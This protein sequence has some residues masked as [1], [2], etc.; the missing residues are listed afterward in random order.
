MSS[1]RI[2]GP[3]FDFTFTVLL[4]VTL[5]FVAASG[6]G[7]AA[8][9]PDVLIA[10][11]EGTNYGTWEITGQ[12][13]G[14]GPAAGTL[15]HQMQVDGYRG[16]KLA[17]SFYGGDSSTGT[18]K[19]ASF[20]LERRYLQFLIGGG[21]QPGKACINLWVDGRNAR[22]ATG[23]NDRPGGSEH[24]DWMQWDV[25]EFAGRTATLEIV[26]QATGGWG[27]INI[28]HIVQ[29]DRRLPGMLTN[30]RHE[31]RVE[32]RYLNFPVKNGVPK[33]RVSVAVQASNGTVI[34]PVNSPIKAE[35]GTAGTERPTFEFEI[36]LAETEPDFWVF[37]DLAPFLG[38]T[39]T[40]QVDKLREDSTALERIEQSATIRGAETLY[41]EPLRPQFHFTSRRGWN[42]DPNGLVFYAGEYH[43]FYQHNPYGWGW[44]NMHW[45]HAISADLVHWRELPIAL[46]PHAFGDWVF[47][48]S[49]VV[50]ARNTGGFK[51]G[52]NDVL[53][54]AYTSTGRGECIAYS[55]DRGRT[56]TEFAGN[57]VVR[58]AGRDPR[59]LWHEPSQRWVMAVYD[60]ADGKR[61]IAF[62]TSAD[63]RAW[64]YQSR[65][66]GFFECPDLFELPVDGDA[67]NRKWV[68]TAA[69]SEYRLGQFDGQRFTPETPMLPGHRGNAFYAAQTYSD[70]PPSDGRRIQIGWG[71]MPTPGMPFNQMMCFPCRLT[72]RTTPE[73]VRLCFEPVEE[74][75]RLHAREHHWKDRA[76][77]PGENPLAA[78]TAEL[79]HVRLTVAPG[80]ASE[81]RLNLRG[82]PIVYRTATAELSFANR[83]AA[84][85]LV[86]GALQLE[87]LVDRTSVELF[88]NG[89]LLYMPVNV[90]V[91]PENRAHSLT[92]TGHARIR[93]LDVYELTSAWTDAA[94]RR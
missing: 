24:L 8:E 12:A 33:R 11:F 18:L 42:N 90:T 21:Q 32:Q 27:H 61:W 64:Q 80:D 74:L 65:I 37:L 53:V 31:L 36:E 79:L 2:G 28:D 82:V 54:A 78:V 92:A 87:V 25:A 46:Y 6:S 3:A 66:E 17:N 75:A 50:D 76:L 52:T 13:F 26:D 56:W 55:N 29:T 58:H 38:K 60:E 43:L 41:R 23:P 39:V 62:Y 35:A 4:I 89:G 30:V 67:K 81:V 91:S 15:P 7:E 83:K 88:G 49:A 34:P 22:T 71:Q 19:S 10:D 63:L 73:G 16:Q 20:R 94:G 69:S 1:K 5:A 47:S 59:L 70:V 48:G 93:S 85:P 72:L 9:R 57:P 45:G 44:G 14:P 77:P 51:S 86:D 84:L 68:L 40:L